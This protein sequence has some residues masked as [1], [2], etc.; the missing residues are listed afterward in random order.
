MLM[1]ARASLEGTLETAMA[2]WVKQ[3]R[4]ARAREGLGAG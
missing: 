1:E 2:M 3:K 4:E